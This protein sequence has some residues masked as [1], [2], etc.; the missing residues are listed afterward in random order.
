MTKAAILA[1]LPKLKPQERTQVF[2]RLC[3]L[4]DDDLKR[5]VGPS[6]KERKILDE[7]QAEFERDGDVGTPWRQALRRIRSSSR[8]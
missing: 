8:R 1:E 5:G 4:Q 3:K 7:A 6:P 2:N